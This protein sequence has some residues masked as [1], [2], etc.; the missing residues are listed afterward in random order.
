M[1]RAS[2][3]HSYGND[4][5]IVLEFEVDESQRGTLSR[6]ICDAHFGVGADGCVFLS[7]AEGGPVDFRIF[8]RDGSE[9]GMSGNGIRCAAAF[10]SHKGIR[11]ADRIDFDTAAGRR[12]LERLSSKAPCW[13]FRADM[14]R[15][16]FRPSEIPMRVD[17]DRDDVFD[18]RLVVA[19]RPVT[20][21]ALSVGNPQCVVFTDTGLSDE[22]FT[23]LGSGLSTHDAFPEQTNV[24]FVE[25]IGRS[26]VRARIWERGVGP[27]H[28]SGTGCS[29]AAVAAL[30]KG[31]VSGPIEVRTETGA[32]RVEWQEGGEIF[33]TGETVFIA[34][35]E[36]EW[37][38]PR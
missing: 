2:K 11:L 26:A 16:R 27:T 1:L 8:N 31:L 19:G 20:I 30:A 24:S 4:F 3:Y 32:Q 23:A 7:L 25:V 22:E 21:A 6:A 28:S 17:E 9:A 36:F 14:G 33:L 5:L 10:L 35:V 12:S 29:G 34:D 38:G 37:A 15:P 18:Y 13:T